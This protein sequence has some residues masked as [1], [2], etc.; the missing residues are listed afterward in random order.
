MIFPR[1]SALW[2]LNHGAL[3]GV[4]ALCVAPLAAVFLPLLESPA[5]SLATCADLLQSERLW[6]LWAKTVALAIATALASTALGAP[7][8]YLLAGNDAAPLRWLAAVLTAPLLVPAHVLAVGWIDVLGQQGVINGIAKAAGLPPHPFPLYS[9][10]GVIL[11]QALT[12]YPLALW[13]VWY[14]ARQIEPEVI[15]A[16]RNLGTPGHTFW[17]IRL[18]LLYPALATAALM[19]FL[20]ALLSFA[21]PSLLQVP[22]FT[23]EIYTS[24]NSLLDQQ[25]AVLMAVPLAL[26]GAATLWLAAGTFRR[27][28]RHAAKTA[29]TRQRTKF[30]R[31]LWA[32]TPIAAVTVGMPLA[33]LFTRSMPP[34]TFA[35]TA[36][37][38]LEELGASL[39][40]AVTGA[41][42]ALAVAVL[43]TWGAPRTPRWPFWAAAMT[44][45]ASGPVFGVGLIQLWNRP[46]IPGYIYDHFPILILAVT[47]RYLIFA[48]L[49][50]QLARLWIATESIE[51]ARA[52]GAS[53]WHTLTRIILPPLRRPLL[54]VWACL[55]L[56]ILGEV[57]CIVLVAPPG[58]VPVS[59]RIFTLMH[60]G[61][62][63]MVS[64]L[65]LIQ[66]ALAV[67][68]LL[69]V[70]ILAEP[71]GVY[72]HR[73]SRY[74]KAGDGRP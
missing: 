29:H 68:A 18:P 15:D 19:T 42:A 50:C 39:L 9:A 27:T 55:A 65:A 44:F 60:Y 28:R 40:L 51:A 73:K 33:A 5:E 34:A 59:L 4:L 69:I 66:G 72:T 45:L 57:E 26:T 13:S 12:C 32:G 7:L 53:T 14:G 46:G 63:A 21:V 35:S 64:A 22:V 6:G 25:R 58:W 61:P 16:A 48:L 2:W 10:A 56:L 71:P 67:A 41:T 30:A 3:A 11:I 62:A 70:R 20:F 23:V 36:S 38:S 47:G 1:P 49:G 74:H 8:G 54:A 43:I 37:S 24:Y 52:L 31:A 17:R